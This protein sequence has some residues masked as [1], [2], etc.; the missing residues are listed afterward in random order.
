MRKVNRN[1]APACLVAGAPGWTLDYVAKREMNPAYKFSWRNQACY[2]AIR[3][4]LVAMTQDHCAFCDG[5]IGTES[6]ETVEHFRP[7]SVFPGLAYEWTNLFPCCDVCQSNKREQF[8]ALLLK[9]DELT[10][11]FEDYFVA[12]FL[13]GALEPRPDAPEEARRRAEVT[14]NL[15]GLNLPARKVARLRE[16][17]SYLLNIEHCIDDYNYRYFLDGNG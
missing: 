1:E 4:Q 3:R 8:D 14:I 5:R 7:K 11:L 15:Y 9:P 16:M 2:D 12:N 17:N 13:T 6:R 10:Y